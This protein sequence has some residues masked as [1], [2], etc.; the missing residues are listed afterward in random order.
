MEICGSVS[1]DTLPARQALA[2]VAADLYRRGWMAGT[3]GNLSVRDGDGFWITASG[4]AKG[5]LQDGDF[6]LMALDSGEMIEAASPA[7]RPSAE[8]SIHQVIYQMVGDAR[9]CL[10][11]H[12]VDACLATEDCED[13]EVL[14]PPLEM[15]K[16]LGVWEQA[17]QVML[18]VFANPLHVPAIAEAIRRR[19]VHQPP[20]I[21]ALMIHR[22]GITAWGTS[23]QQALNHLEVI[24]FILSWM[25]RRRD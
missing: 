15:L 13:G 8:A 10:H 23:L 21:P 17:P 12:T 24:E 16:G 22:H 6:V 4:R 20:T 14:L 18:P 9:A 1:I 19:F 5:Q 11:V 25:A 7:A 3:A 2:R